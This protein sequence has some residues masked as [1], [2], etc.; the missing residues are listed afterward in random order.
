MKIVHLRGTSAS[1][2]TCLARSLIDDPRGEWKTDMGECLV[3]AIKVRKIQI[4]RGYVSEPWRL[5]VVGSYVSVC[6][7]AEGL[8]QEEITARVLTQARAGYNVVFEGLLCGT[9]FGRWYDLALEVRREGYGEYISCLMPAT[10]EECVER[11]RL[12]REA[13][14]TDRPITDKT[15]HITWSNHHSCARAHTK[16]AAHGILAEILPR[17]REAARVREILNL[18]EEL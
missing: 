5:Y 3:S 18:P 6:G 17:L 11:L 2:K 16:M 8:K 13:K 15:K 14:G 9:S 1:G 10:V 12:R 4:P 7:G